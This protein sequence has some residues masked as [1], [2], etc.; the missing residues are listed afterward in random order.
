MDKLDFVLESIKTLKEKKLASVELEKREEVTEETTLDEANFWDGKPTLGR[1]SFDRMKRKQHEYEADQESAATRRH[2][3]PHHVY[4]NKKIWKKDGKPVEFTS[5]LHAERSAASIKK[6][7]PSKEVHF[8]HHSYYKKHGDTIKEETQLSEE[9]HRV[10]VSI[11]DPNH[12][13]VSKRKEKIQRHA[14]VSATSRDEAITKAK[15]FYKKKGYKVHDA[16]HVGMVNEEVELDENTWDKAWE[17]VH[18]KEKGPIGRFLTRTA[19]RLSGTKIDRKTG[20]VIPKKSVKEE[21]ELDEGKALKRFM[22]KY[23]PGQAAKQIHDKI[24]DQ[25]FTQGLERDRPEPDDISVKTIKQTARNIRRYKKFVKED[26][27]LDESKDT[28]EQ[29]L[30]DMDINSSVSGKSVKVHMS[31]ISKARNALK[32]AGYSDHTVSG[33]LNQ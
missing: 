11:S 31:N 10:L 5:R 7:D 24:K 15:N 18:S 28:I 3:E 8:A 17:I 4:I 20:K 9:K 27:E 6:K 16:E 33:G 25:Q 23:I 1:G 12:G 2:A 32:K 29:M 14:K 30:A 13:M 21:L 22:R 26:V 19:A